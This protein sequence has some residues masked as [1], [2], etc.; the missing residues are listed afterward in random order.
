MSFDLRARVREPAAE[1]LRPDSSASQDEFDAWYDRYET[2]VLES[3]YD[4]PG[5]FSP[6]NAAFAIVLEALRQ[7]GALWRPPSPHDNQPA[8]PLSPRPRG[9]R[10]E[11]AV[12]KL[13]S[14]EGWYVTPSESKF[15]ADAL[16]SFLSSERAMEIEE[17]DMEALIAD[18]RRNP[19]PTKKRRYSLAA[20]G[21]DTNV[22]TLLQK[23]ISFFRHAEAHG[24]EVW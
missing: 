17:V 23:A 9:P 5:W 12:E 21:A 19:P 3:A 10:G 14:N 20:D 1:H 24:F 8:D 4:S 11:V 16:A 15:L 13:S 2:E 22:V 7:G 18:P 6:N